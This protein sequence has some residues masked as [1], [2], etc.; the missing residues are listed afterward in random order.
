MAGVSVVLGC[1]LWCFQLV[2]TEPVHLLTVARDA[3]PLVQDGGF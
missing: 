2:N 1:S 3:E